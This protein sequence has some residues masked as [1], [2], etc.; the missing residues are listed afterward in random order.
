[1]PLR[2]FGRLAIILAVPATLGTHCIFS[3]SYRGPSMA[4]GGTTL[5]GPTSNRP[6]SPPHAV[7]I[8]SFA[9]PEFVGLYRPDGKFRTS[10]SIALSSAQQRPWENA[11]R[12]EVPA[13]IDLGPAEYVVEDFEPTA[14]AVRPA[15]G[16]SIFATL[17]DGLVTLAYGREKVLRAPTHVTTDSRQRLIVTDPNLPAVHILDVDRKKSFR[18]AGGPQH[19]LQQPTGVAVDTDDNIYVADGKKGVVVVYDPQGQFLRYIGSFRGESMFQS[20]AGIAIDRSA[21]RLY[22]L[23]PPAQQ[24]IMLDLSGAVLKR[25]GSKRSLQ[26]AASLEHPT[27]IAVGRDLVAIIDSGGSRIEVFDLQCNFLKAFS[28]RTPN[29]PPIVAEM[30]L[31][32]DSASNIYV[33]NLN[34]SSVLTYDRDGR[35]IGAFGRYGTGIKEFD[36]PSGVWI[37]RSDRMYVADTR[38]SRVQ[39]FHVS[40]EGTAGTQVGRSSDGQ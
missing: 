37:D 23:D 4:S 8:R 27:E 11:R 20:P 1:M 12:T 17:R 26:T 21:G 15:R 19:R 2:W 29:G 14:H 40:T 22:V 13:Y 33:S 24:L 10:T 6:P 3:Q 25:V 7:P 34:G 35:V 16:R 38:N 36:G 30:G 32:L 31:A 18:V 5:S 28:I 9:T 39:V